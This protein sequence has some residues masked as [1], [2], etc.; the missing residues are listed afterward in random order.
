MMGFSPLW[1]QRH[2][3]HFSASALSVLLHKSSLVFRVTTP[4]RGREH[5]WHAHVIDISVN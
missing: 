2:Q 4:D 3:V 5:L 1:T